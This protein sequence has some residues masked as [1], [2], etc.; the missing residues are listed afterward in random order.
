MRTMRYINLLDKISRVKTSKCF[1]Y[2]NTVFFAVSK[3]EVF[4]AIG[5][6]A[7]NV[8]KLQESIGAR[9]RIIRESEGIEDIKHFID[10]I[11]AP[12]RI[13]SL[14]VKDNCLFITAGNNQTK[15]TLFG[16]NKKRYEELKQIV[17]DNFNL[18]LR[19]V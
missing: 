8:K 9:I 10:D 1:V 7:F 3:Y 17:E 5:P 16:R 12:I 4:K 18:S 13:K 2:N 15:A 19:I 11:I 14:E 6:A